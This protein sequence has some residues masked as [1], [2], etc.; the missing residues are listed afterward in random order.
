M[1]KP[2][3]AKDTIERDVTNR[4]LI[5]LRELQ[6]KPEQWQKPWDGMFS[7]GFPVRANGKPF[8]GINIFLLLMEGRNDPRWFT[9]D[10]AKERVGYAK[11]PEWK[12]KAD[13]YKGIPK[14]IWTGEGEDPHFGIRKGETGTKVVRV[15]VTPIFTDVNDDRVYPPRG[16]DPKKQAAWAAQI[17]SGAV[18]K[19][20]AYTKVHLYTVFNAEQVEGLPPAMVVKNVNPAERYAAAEALVAALGADIIH[21]PGGNVA[22]YRPGMDGITLPE[23]GQFR[24]VEDYVATKFHEVIHWTGHPDRLNRTFGKV[25]GDKDYA[26][27]ELVAELGAAFLCAHTGVEGHLQHPQYLASWIKELED[28]EKAIFR[29]ASL[30]QKATDFVLNGGK[31]TSEDEGADEDVADTDLAA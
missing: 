10:Q 23:P 26:F 14:W 30:A 15:S 20:G 7:H 24:T 27:E 19:K 29:A 5:R 12:G 21:V 28:N 22:C 3:S 8:T 25:F 11:N 17:A 9:F 1:A 16:Q 4:I 13:T 31:G 2:D 6:A 18:R